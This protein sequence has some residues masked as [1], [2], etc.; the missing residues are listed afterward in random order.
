M[1]KCIFCSDYAGSFIRT[2]Y[3]YLPGV[4][5]D[6]AGADLIVN[7]PSCTE[8]REILD[9]VSIASL[10]GAARYLSL[11]YSEVYAHLLAE[12]KWSRGELEELGYNLRSS[13]EMSHKA[14]LEVTDRVEQCKRVAVLGPLL[15]DE[16]MDDIR[17]EVS[18]TLATEAAH[19]PTQRSPP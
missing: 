1:I 12:V 15:P 11:V 16:V 9:A 4:N 3:S 14:H 5:D 6:D 19:I 10:E 8:C 13:I 18:S 17:Y 2:P 7:L